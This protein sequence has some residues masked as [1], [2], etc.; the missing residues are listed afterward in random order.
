[1]LKKILLPAVVI[2]TMPVI[3]FAQEGEHPGFKRLHGLDLT[4]E[5]QGQIEALTTET[6]KEHLPI[7][8][9]LQTM[10]AELDE[11]LIAANPNRNAI[12]RKID[13][14]S[15]LRTEMQ[16]ARIDTRLR[17]RELL[18]DDQRVKFDAMRSHGPGKRM[19]RHGRPG[20][21]G[22]MRG[23]RGGRPG[24]HRGHRFGDAEFPS[25]TDEEVEVAE[26]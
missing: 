13:E 20:R 14:M 11:L 19:M 25:E 18:T 22:G 3:V 23:D 10:K 4:E 24:G 7:R 16:K 8:S 2:L 15:D 26:F 21:M 1:M 17:I 12:D 9:R 5:Q 6:M